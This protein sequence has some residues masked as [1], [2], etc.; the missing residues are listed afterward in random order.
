MKHLGLHSMGRRNCAVHVML[1]QCLQ[2]WTAFFDPLLPGRDLRAVEHYERVGEFGPARQVLGSGKV[3][4]SLRCEHGEHRKEGEG[5]HGWLRWD[6]RSIREPHPRC[7]RPSAL[8]HP[9]PGSRS[10]STT[11]IRVALKIYGEPL[12]VDGDAPEGLIRLDELLPVFRQ[13]DDSVID[14]AVARVEANGDKV[15]CSKG[16]SAC[17]RAQ[18]VPVTPPE[19]YALL[20]LVESLPEQRQSEVRAAF[21]NRAA[22]LRTAELHD[23]FMRRETEVSPEQARPR[24]SLLPPRPGLSIPRRRRVRNLRT[25]TVCLPAVPGDFPGGALFRPPAQPGQADTDATAVR[26]RGAERCRSSDWPAAAHRAA[27]ACS[28]VRGGPPR[29]T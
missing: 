25:A 10:M 9:P 28:G 23:S 20:R 1:K 27:G 13:V 4:V 29:R 15:S 21:A 22:R 18:P 7:K 17:C 16:C 5:T 19:A 11:R 2:L 8:Q 12:T 26:H 24:R 6:G 14:R 3:R